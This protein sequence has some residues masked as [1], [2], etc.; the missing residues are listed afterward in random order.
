[1]YAMRE[2]LGCRLKYRLPLVAG[3]FLMLHLSQGVTCGA[4]QAPK[5]TSIATK[6]PAYRF[7][8]IGGARLQIA[9]MGTTPDLPKG[10]IEE[11]MAR[12]AQAVSTYYGRFPVSSAR[13]V[14]LVSPAQHG[15]LQGTTW[16]NVDGLPAV[17]RLRIGE[18]TTER[19]L[20]GEWMAT[21]EFVHMALASLPDA[22]HWLEEGVAT[23]VEPIARVQ[24]GQLMPERIW[25]DMVAG[26]HNGEPEAGDR[27]LNRT[28][29]W[30]RTYWG[31]A[32]FCLMAD[33]E[34]RKQ[35]GNTRGLQDALRAIVAAG[36][37]I[38]KE[39]PV[40]RI[41]RIGDQATGTSVLQQ[42]YAKWS[43]AP[44]EVDLPHLWSELGVRVE[45]GKIVFDDAAPLAKIRIGITAIPAGKVS[46]PE[47]AGDGNAASRQRVGMP[48][49]MPDSSGGCNLCDWARS[50]VWNMLERVPLDHS[51]RETP[52]SDARSLDFPVL[53]RPA[54][55]GARPN[56]ERY[57]FYEEYFRT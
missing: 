19:E 42:L 47:F 7:I 21:H 30:G 10:A 55:K 14:V 8:Q 41:L 44:V 16:G 25:G 26:M 2:R 3:A 48:K 54:H 1:M 35:T 57:S 33:I 29:T 37:T 40:M 9:L 36:G 38:D 23:Y 34:I 22:Q 6:T 27:G 12:A 24:A 56:H 39:W 43:E 13:V 11:H 4:A 50:N 32:L 18:R 46:C 28:H 15:M 20:N 53:Q 49:K 52:L 31:G 17:T 5:V 51:Y 45:T